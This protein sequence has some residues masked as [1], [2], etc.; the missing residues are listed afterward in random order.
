MPKD[1]NADNTELTDNIKPTNAETKPKVVKKKSADSTPKASK[2]KATT[3]E[4]KPKKTTAEP[5]SKKTTSAAADST[6]K[7]TNV[8]PEQIKVEKP[9][10]QDVNVDKSKN[11]KVS[12]EDFLREEGEETGPSFKRTKRISPILILIITF[13]LIS[14]TT[15]VLI[16]SLGNRGHKTSSVRVEVT[17]ILVTD[18]TTSTQL[19]QPTVVNF[20]NQEGT[21]SSAGTAIDVSIQTNQ[22]VMY[23]YK[24]NNKT[25]F[26]V[27][28]QITID[29]I[30]NTNFHITY[31]DTAI[32]EP[33][34]PYDL[35]VMDYDGMITGTLGKFKEKFVVVYFKIDNQDLDASIH[36]NL[37][38]S[39]SMV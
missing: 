28:F 29:K 17:P 22:Y 33:N 6:P 7:T 8:E 5:K 26:D 21:T 25:E 3:A 31:T 27:D 9:K 12:T 13:L 4:Q 23:Q 18:N 20:I 38:L 30:A 14:A 32:R 24:L 11:R 35:K 10:A 34:E 2:P 1:N 16:V 39:L 15:T 37:T 36:G 19:T